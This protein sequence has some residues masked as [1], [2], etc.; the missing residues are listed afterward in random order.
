MKQRIKIIHF[1][2]NV[3]SVILVKTTNKKFNLTKGQIS[4][5]CVKNR[6]KK[7]KTEKNR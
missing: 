4:R 1:R 5:K 7:K 6:K 2:F 3:L